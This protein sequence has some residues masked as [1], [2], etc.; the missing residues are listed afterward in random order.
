MFTG[1]VQ[2]MG[3]VSALGASSG[4]MRLTIDALFALTNVVLGE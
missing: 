2:G 3:R 1:L 4:Q